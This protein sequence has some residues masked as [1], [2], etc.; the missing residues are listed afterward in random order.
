MAT[1]KLQIRER[2]NFRYN[3]DKKGFNSM[4]TFV[5]RC[6]AM[7]GFYSWQLAELFDE[8]REMNEGESIYFFE[9][10]AHLFKAKSVEEAEGK[11][12]HWYE[13]GKKDG[14]ELFRP[15]VCGAFMIKKTA[16]SLILKNIDID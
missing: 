11:F 13:L 6:I 9:S 2:N 5:F 7:D 14:W 4:R 8:V 15:K 1:F 16:K 10:E 12:N 3:N